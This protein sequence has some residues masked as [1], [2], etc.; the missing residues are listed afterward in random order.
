MHA[1]RQIKNSQVFASLYRAVWQ[2]R[3]QGAEDIGESKQQMVGFH[4]ETE[5]RGKYLDGIFYFH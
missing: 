3:D 5:Q 2:S 1:L 4:W